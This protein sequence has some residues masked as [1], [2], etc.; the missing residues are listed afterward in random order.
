M[1][2]KIGSMLKNWKQF[3]IK[4]GILKG[5]TSAGDYHLIAEIIRADGLQP[6]FVDQIKVCR[7]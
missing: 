7:D 2:H 5:C 1:L 4:E 3:I 6:K